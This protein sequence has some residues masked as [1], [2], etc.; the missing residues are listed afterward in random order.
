M[1]LIVHEFSHPYCNPLI[2]EYWSS[3]ENKAKEL[4]NIV[5][6][7]MSNN[8]YS[9]VSMMSETLVR[10]SAIRYMLTHNQE[11]LVEQAILNEVNG[12]FLMVKML[13]ELL[14]K[15]EQASG[16][17]ASLAAFM[18]EIVNAINQ[19]DPNNPSTPDE[20]DSLPHDYVDLGIELDNGKKLYFA[21]RNVGETSPGGIGSNV[22][23]W[24]TT[25]AWGTAWT[26]ETT[27]ELWPIGHKLDAAHDIATIEWGGD[28]HIPTIEEWRSLVAQCDS[29]KKWADESGY[30]VIG[31]FFY[32][33]KDRS[34]F[35]FIPSTTW[36]WSSEIDS[37]LDGYAHARV[38]NEYNDRFGTGGT[39]FINGSFPIRPVI[40]ASGKFDANGHEYVDLG[41]QTSDG[42]KL[43]FATMNVGETSPAGV[44]N[45]S[46]CWGA[47]EEGGEPWTKE[48]NI[49][50]PTGKKLD[51][52]H[53]IA[54]IKWGEK[55]HIPSPEEW[56]LLVEKCD[57]ERKEA[58]KSGYDVAGYFFYN[59]KDHS[60]YIFLPVSLWSDEL[61]YW[62]SVI[63]EP[64]EGICVAHTFNSFKGNV[65]C[66]NRASINSRGFAIRPVFVE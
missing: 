13:V 63:S 32:N 12:G 48:V 36:Y 37:H 44:L 17:Y 11:D 30:G 45:V 41:I 58:D 49:V 3:I 34:K 6:S 60:K 53:D 15:Y 2:D 35:I 55:W 10:A 66:L 42:K 9:I 19:F 39:A 47:T 8:A 38:F 24:G 62:T 20:P 43:Y 31:H 52:A 22:Y 27:N 4:Y 21:T 29:E 64:D 46:Y 23:R 40:T 26:P 14:E 7:T 56:K 25:E 1:N 5:G 18:P 51:A 59:K 54:T 28:W 16:K 57:Y 61:E 50:W 65:G 33:K